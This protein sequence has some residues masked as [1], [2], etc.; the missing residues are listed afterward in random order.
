MANKVDLIWIWFDLSGA[1]TNSHFST[2]SRRWHS[3]HGNAKGHWSFPLLH[4][5]L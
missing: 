3:W 2:D 4:H 5:R 1:K